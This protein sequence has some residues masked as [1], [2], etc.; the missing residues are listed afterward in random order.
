MGSCLAHV[1][2]GY[3]DAGGGEV[4]VLRMMNDDNMRFLFD[5]SRYLDYVI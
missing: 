5:T 1:P 3:H 2:R 4:V